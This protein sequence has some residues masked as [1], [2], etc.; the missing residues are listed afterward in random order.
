MTKMQDQK[1]KVNPIPII[2][3]TV[4]EAVEELNQTIFTNKM[5]HIK[6]MMTIAIMETQALLDTIQ[7]ESP[8]LESVQE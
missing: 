3:E 6:Q 7:L 8:N 5:G 4:Y 2:Q 1:K